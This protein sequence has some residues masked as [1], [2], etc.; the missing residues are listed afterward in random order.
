MPFLCRRGR[1]EI[2]NVNLNLSKLIVFRFKLI[3]LNFV[4]C[5]WWESD[6]RKKSSECKA[7]VQIVTLKEYVI[8]KRILSIKQRIFSLPTN[9]FIH[10][11]NQ[12][13]KYI[14]QPRMHRIHSQIF[15]Y[16]SN[17]Q[18]GALYLEYLNLLG[19]PAAMK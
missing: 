12:L 5:I 8:Y 18:S 2:S 16:T 1:Q 10:C 3:W 6:E 4:I 15:K 19:R 14:L 13:V 7:V 11:A 17:L 9:I